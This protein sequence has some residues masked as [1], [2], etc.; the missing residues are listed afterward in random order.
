[1]L[2]PQSLSVTLNGY[3]TWK[4]EN[5]HATQEFN[6]NQGWNHWPH[7]Y[8]RICCIPWWRVNVSMDT[9]NICLAY[10]RKHGQEGAKRFDKLLDVLCGL[11]CSII[12]QECL[13][14][15]PVHCFTHIHA[16]ENVLEEEGKIRKKILGDE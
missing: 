4:E 12:T 11:C 8:T 7:A 13:G 3:E 14:L 16:E 5:A 15:Q 10:V 6:D 9:C 2:Q 1:M